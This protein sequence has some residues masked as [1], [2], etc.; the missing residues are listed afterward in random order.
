MKH[1]SFLVL[2][3]VLMLSGCS[4]TG[5]QSATAGSSANGS[6]ASSSSASDQTNDELI[7][8]DNIIVADDQNVTVALVNYYVKPT[9]WSEGARDEKCIT[10]KVTNKSDRNIL[11]NLRDA[12]INDEKVKV[13][14]MNGNSGPKPGKSG[15]YGYYV[16]YDT[17]PNP[18]ELESLDKLNEL[19]GSFEICVMD[20]ED[21]YIEETY[22]IDFNLAS[23]IN[24][25][26]VSE[27]SAENNELSD[28]KITEILTA[29]EKWTY[30][31]P[32]GNTGMQIFY[33]DGTVYFDAGKGLVFEDAEWNITEDK[34]IKV[35][36]EMDGT[37]YGA[38]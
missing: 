29:P 11:F 27:Q 8:F 30:T 9:N 4:G 2:A 12:Y 36:F 33:E 26:S 31:S 15:N 1:K 22:E 10:F 32:E 34:T 5:N 6:A 19:D 21:N 17:S 18:T 7:E 23:A 25:E 37:K 38:E 20:A 35:T 28:E 3:A 16:D 24:G 13:I 14:M